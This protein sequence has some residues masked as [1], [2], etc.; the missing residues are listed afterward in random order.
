MNTSVSLVTNISIW[1]P[2][3][4]GWSVN[5]SGLSAF[6]D[7]KEAIP[8]GGTTLFAMIITETIAMDII[9][10]GMATLKRGMRAN[11]DLELCL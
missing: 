1:D 9:S 4:S 8:I 3:M 2:A 5:R 7:G 10:Q 11:I 6:M